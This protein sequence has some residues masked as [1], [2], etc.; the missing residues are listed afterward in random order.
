MSTL[1][2][3][4]LS[5]MVWRISNIFV[6]LLDRNQQDIPK[7]TLH[8][9]DVINDMTSVSK[10]SSLGCPHTGLTLLLQLLSVKSHIRERTPCYFAGGMEKAASRSSSTKV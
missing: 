8:I 7:D 1:Q 4:L 3:Y 10:F 6:N 9:D 2:H 5:T